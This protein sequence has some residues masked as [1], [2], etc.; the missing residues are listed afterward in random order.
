MFGNLPELPKEKN[1]RNPLVEAI[2]KKDEVSEKSPMKIKKG[3]EASTGLHVS[4]CLEITSPVAFILG[5]IGSKWS[6]FSRMRARGA[7]ATASIPILRELFQGSRRT[8]Q[9]LEALPGMSTKTLMVRLRELEKYGL[10]KRQVYSEVP[11]LFSAQVIPSILPL[12][13]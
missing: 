8:H 4:Q 10:V 11:R 9:L 12:A 7:A 2:I 13:S 1:G 5:R 6:Q 3:Y